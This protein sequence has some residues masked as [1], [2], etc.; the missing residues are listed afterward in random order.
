[1]EKIGHYV[2]SHLQEWVRMVLQNREL[3][4]AYVLLLNRKLNV[5]MGAGLSIPSMTVT[6]ALHDSSSGTWYPD[7]SRVT[8]PVFHAHLKTGV[9]YFLG[10]RLAL[11]TGLGCYFGK[12]GGDDGIIGLPGIHTS[13]SIRTSQS[14]SVFL[15]P[16][17]PP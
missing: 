1:M 2:R 5:S 10:P 11:N 8:C 13:R 15:T 16:S 6:S 12:F 14:F 4:L 9:E 7:Q 17:F 3:D